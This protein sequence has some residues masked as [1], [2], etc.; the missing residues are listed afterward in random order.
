VDMQSIYHGPIHV[1]L[2]GSGKVWVGESR[3]EAGGYTYWP[4]T[5]FAS[6]ETP[7]PS[8]LRNA[9]EAEVTLSGKFLA[10][11]LVLISKIEN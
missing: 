11:H 3:F 9:R 10:Y 2:K 1:D 8:I 5:I 7:D 4:K 6:K